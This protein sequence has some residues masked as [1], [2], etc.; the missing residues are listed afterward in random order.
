MAEQRPRPAPAFSEEQIVNWLIEE[1][2]DA[3]GRI[4][5]L[6]GSGDRILTTG[7]AVLALAATVAVG[8]DRGHLLMALPFGVAITIV[9]GFYL[10]NMA[11]TLSAYKIALEK[12]ITRRVGVPIIAWSS[13]A[14]QG[15]HVGRP[16]A[17]LLVLAAI[18]YLT[19]V[20]IGL[21]QAI[22]TMSPG[23]W[24]HELGWLYLTA[25][26]ASILIGSG[27][28]GYSLIGI[29]DRWAVTRQM[30]LL[31]SEAASEPTT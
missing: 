4:A 25:T 6:S 16:R 21:S 3:G 7:S 10:N 11:R 8:G 26:I 28:I 30:D 27:T 13:H 18:V 20:G 31:L 23:A 2:R 19:S 9:F 5:T 24:G 15:A 14:N 1:C 29:R 17:S 22:R 12:E